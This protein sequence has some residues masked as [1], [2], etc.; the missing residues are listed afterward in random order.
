MSVAVLERI[1]KFN[2]VTKPK[3]DAMT[4][5]SKVIDAAKEIADPAWEKLKGQPKEVK[6][7]FFYELGVSIMDEY[8][9][10][11]PKEWEALLAIGYL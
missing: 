5:D 1:V 11:Y 9:N 4:F 7:R 8:K 6:Q 2:S 3:Q 10:E